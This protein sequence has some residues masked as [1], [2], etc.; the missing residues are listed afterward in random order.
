MLLFLINLWI[1]FKLSRLQKPPLELLATNSSTSALLL[2]ELDNWRD[3]AK[4]AVILNR[5]LLFIQT[6][7]RFYIV[8]G[9]YKTEDGDV[10]GHNGVV[11]NFLDY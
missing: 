1:A 2:N 9:I 6:T 4:V 11:T 3:E 7:G 8:A 5:V 10:T